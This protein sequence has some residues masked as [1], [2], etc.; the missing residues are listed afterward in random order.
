[1]RCKKA[2][3]L[4][5]VSSTLR[6]KREF[7]ITHKLFSQCTKTGYDLLYKAILLRKP[8]ELSK[9]EP[10]EL[11]YY[12]HQKNQCLNKPLFEANASKGEIFKN[13]CG[14]SLYKLSR[15][16]YQ[17]LFLFAGQSRY[18]STA[19]NK[20]TVENF[21]GNVIDTVE[22]WKASLKLLNKQVLTNYVRKEMKLLQT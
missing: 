17:D 16:K 2:G 18:V 10:T 13:F 5:K 21:G 6:N 22:S 4:V 15:T 19:T 7:R 14:L 12:P 11:K 3:F 1:M 9:V 20:E 8:V